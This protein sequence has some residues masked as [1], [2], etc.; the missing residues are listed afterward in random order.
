MRVEIKEFQILM[1]RCRYNAILTF[2]VVIILEGSGLGAGDLL[3]VGTGACKVLSVLEDSGRGSEYFAGVELIFVKSCS[4]WMLLDQVFL[5]RGVWMRGWFLLGLVL[6]GGLPILFWLVGSGSFE[7]TL[8]V[9][10][11]GSRVRDFTRVYI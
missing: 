10:Y 3:R 4:F 5:S 11:L 9:P 6:L 1:S 2:L 8:E 7:V